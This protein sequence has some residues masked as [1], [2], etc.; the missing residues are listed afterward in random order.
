M[1][2]YVT[3]FGS[4]TFERRLF[5]SRGGRFEQT[6]SAACFRLCPHSDDSPPARM[7]EK[8]HISNSSLNACLIFLLDIGWGFQCKIFPT[9]H[10]PSRHRTI[11]SATVHSLH[12]SPNSRLR[13]L[14][15][16][17]ASQGCRF[18]TKGSWVCSGALTASSQSSQPL[19][20]LML[21]LLSA[22]S[23]KIRSCTS[24]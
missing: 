23:A 1:P 17:A 19:I 6:Q 8:Y 13:K 14:L 21:H 16:I 20:Q 18:C 15:S 9:L 10:T 11:P 5:P 24:L 12:G 7:K 4:M 3:T 2:Q 22:N